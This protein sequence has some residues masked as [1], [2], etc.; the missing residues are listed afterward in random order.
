MYYGGFLFPCVDYSIAF[1]H[2]NTNIQI[3]LCAYRNISITA[4]ILRV[5][6]QE[7]FTSEVYMCA[8][9]IMLLR[10][11]TQLSISFPV[12]LCLVL[13]SVIHLILWYKWYFNPPALSPSWGGVF[14][15]MVGS[16]N[17]CLKKI[18]LGSRIAFEEL[19]TVL[20]EIEL[21][22]NNRQLTLTC[23]IGDE[24]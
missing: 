21:T 18:I 24:M 11:F 16:I 2:S 7:D 10:L 17:R 4:N 22:L 5:C 19:E 23:E 20:C 8:I 12:I 15:R 1:N 9:N 13:N 6:N 3:I 14:V